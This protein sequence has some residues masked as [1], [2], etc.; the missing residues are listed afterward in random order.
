M[1]FSKIHPMLRKP[2][3]LTSHYRHH[4]SPTKLPRPL[5]P[6]SRLKNS[7]L[8]SRLESSISTPDLRRI[9]IDADVVS[10]DGKMPGFGFSFFLLSCSSYIQE[11]VIASNES[12]QAPPEM[13]KL[14][15]LIM[16]SLILMTNYETRRASAAFEASTLFVIDFSARI[17]IG[18]ATLNRS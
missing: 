17:A 18:V 10:A 12:L 4:R 14:I 9:I 11:F 13:E 1:L 3:P 5:R 16:Q 6:L 15:D 8:N 2:N 7:K